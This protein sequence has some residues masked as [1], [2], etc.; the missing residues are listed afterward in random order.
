MPILTGEELHDCSHGQ[1]IRSLWLGWVGLERGQCTLLSLFHSSLM[2][3]VCSVLSCLVLSCL[4]LSCLVSSR[5]VSSTTEWAL[6]RRNGLGGCGC[7]CGVVVVV[8]GWCWL[9]LVGVGWCWL[10]LVGVGWCWLVLVGVGWCWLV[11]VGVG[12]C[13]LVLVGVGWCWLVLVGVGWLVLVGVG[14]LVLVGVG[15][16]VLV[17]GGWL[18]GWLV[19]WWLV[20]GWLVVGWWLVGWWLLMG[21]T[22]AGIQRLSLIHTLKNTVKVEKRKRGVVEKMAY[23]TL[24]KKPAITTPHTFGNVPQKWSNKK[25]KKKQTK[26]KTPS[27]KR[28][29]KFAQPRCTLTQLLAEQT[30]TVHTLLF[31]HFPTTFWYHPLS[32]NPF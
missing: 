7:G 14:W 27:L 11:L 13:W 22:K 18:V 2:C 16:L 21:T 32:V 15:W 28:Q 31:F 1:E 8:V 19:G 5:L 4:V 9:V 12:W 17:G 24:S 10:V 25:K 26:S 20:G 6:L 30:E 29:K 3:V 23:Q